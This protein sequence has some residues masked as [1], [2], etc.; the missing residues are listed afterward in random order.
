[1]TY[2][3]LYVE[4]GVNKT[5]IEINGTSIIIGATETLIIFG[6]F[7]AYLALRLRSKA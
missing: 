6:L 4:D 2:V 1:M 7:F 5:M 3:I